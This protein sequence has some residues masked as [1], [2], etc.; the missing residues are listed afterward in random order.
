VVDSAV[1]ISN[2]QLCFDDGSCS[3][4]FVHNPLNMMQ[5]KNLNFIIFGYNTCY[6]SNYI[7]NLPLVLLNLERK[8]D[9][10]QMDFWAKEELHSKK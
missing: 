10:A 9:Q 1:T 8:I 2:V 3:L 4:G 5:T 6:I 7:Y